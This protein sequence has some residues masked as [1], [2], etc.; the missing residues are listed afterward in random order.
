M[1]SSRPKHGIWFSLLFYAYYFAMDFIT[2]NYV[3]VCIW[4]HDVNIICYKKN[5]YLNYI[6]MSTQT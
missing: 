5:I 3:F 2:L 4:I 1:Y 6:K